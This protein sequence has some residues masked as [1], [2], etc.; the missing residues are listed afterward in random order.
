MEK[1]I[2]ISICQQDNS[3]KS[4]ISQITRI[5]DY[6]IQLRYFHLSSRLSEDPITDIYAVSNPLFHS[7]IMD[8]IK[9]KPILIVE[10]GENSF[11][12]GS[13]NI[14]TICKNQK[15][16]E[17]FLKALVRSF[18]SIKLL[19]SD[20]RTVKLTF[21]LP[22]SKLEIIQGN[23]VK[24]REYLSYRGALVLKELFSKPERVVE[25]KEFIN[26]GIKE[27][28]LPV[29]ISTLR[30]TL[31]KIAPELEIKSHRSKGYS[32]RFINNG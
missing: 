32:L 30:K 8:E 13:E 15:S 19:L 31:K 24:G 7:I 12:T 21:T 1:V 25:F 20:D 16:I 22:E 29:Y 2:T 23:R 11:Q 10:D 27:E 14:F 6:R 3:L 17:S 28:S 26:L 4:V 9:E 5:E 18:K